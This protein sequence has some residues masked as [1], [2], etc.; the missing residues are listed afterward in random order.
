MSLCPYPN[1]VPVCQGEEEIRGAASSQAE[2]TLSQS[3]DTSVIDM[4]WERSEQWAFAAQH[5]RPEPIALLDMALEK[6]AV[7]DYQLLGLASDVGSKPGYTY[8]GHIPRVQVPLL[9][10]SLLSLTWAMW[11]VLHSVGK[12]WQTV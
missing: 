2:Q 10:R 7:V 4:F 1:D 12:I 11:K 3:P 6:D 5:I 8:L 9:N